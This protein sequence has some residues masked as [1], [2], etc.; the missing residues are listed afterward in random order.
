MKR[1]RVLEETRRGLAKTGF[2]LSRP[3]GERGL[4][5]DFVAR[6]DDTLLIVKFL[7]NVDA[8]SKDTAH[9]LLEVARILEGSP[10]VGPVDPFALLADPARPEGRLPQ[11]EGF[12][13]E[14]FE[15]LERLGYQVLRTVRS[16]FDAL[17]KHEDT[18]FLTGVGEADRALERKAEVVSN[19][20]RVVEKDSV[21][22][23]ERA[24]VRMSI[25]GVPVI[26]R[27]ELRRAKDRDDVEEMISE[28][29]G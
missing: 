13:R 9:E 12:E 3:H 5:F 26:A 24:R 16:P 28:K 29:K 21:M 4:C 2:F 25:R 18:T 19:L 22:F 10:L 23:V 20:S 14:M 11:L 6:R 27:E 15:R 8:L 17:S 7:Q 1:D